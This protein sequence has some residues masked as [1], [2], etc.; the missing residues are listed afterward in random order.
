MPILGTPAFL[1]E[2]NLDK[3]CPLLTNQYLVTFTPRAEYLH[4][5]TITCIGR[6]AS[7]SDTETKLE[8]FTSSRAL[9]R[10]KV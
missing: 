5:I 4:G 2:K 6:K 10:D 7:L 3:L 9:A 1:E 8:I